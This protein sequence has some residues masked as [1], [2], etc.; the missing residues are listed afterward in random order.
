MCIVTA[1]G[2]MTLTGCSG[3]TGSPPSES[4][5]AAIPRTLTP[6]QQAKVDKAAAVARAL[7]AP[8][9]TPD[10]VLQQHGMT[11]QQFNDLLFEIAEDEA[12]SA[13]YDAKV[14]S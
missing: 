13:A 10:Q 12:M 7:E 3:E 14:G 2:V 4:S 5:S 8:G 11:E 9:Q 6:E 1:V